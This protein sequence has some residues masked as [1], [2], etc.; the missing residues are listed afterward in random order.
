MHDCAVWFADAL[1]VALDRPRQSFPSNDGS[2]SSVKIFACPAFS[3][4]SADDDQ[5]GVL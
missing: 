2:S 4:W 5:R 3:F 1:N